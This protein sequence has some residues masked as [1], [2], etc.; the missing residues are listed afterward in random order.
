MN[1][2]VA[3]STFDSLME[4]NL[5]FFDERQQIVQHNDKGLKFQFILTSALARK[6]TFQ[7]NPDKGEEQVDNVI[8]QVRDGSD[9]N[10][11]GY[12]MCDIGKTHF[13]AANKF[14]FARPHLMLLT[15]DG[16]KRQYEPLDEDDWQALNSVLTD[17]GD[18]YVAFFNCGQ[19]GGC[20][21]L[22]KHMQLIPKPKDSFAAFLDTENGVEPDV[23]FQWFYHHFESP[24]LDSKELFGIYNKLLQKA[25]EA[26]KDQSEHTDSLPAGAAIPHNM[27]VT[28]QWMIVLPRRQ[29]AVN[30]KAGANSIGMMGVIAVAT[31]EEIDNWIRIGPVE[32]LKELG[33]PKIL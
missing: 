25:T 18:D 13:L 14:C 10:T 30:K 29:A 8:D 33:V 28:N 12:E 5:V 15:S 3:L 11:T 6:P 7:V 17:L 22:H 1:D 20:S 9:I 23:P 26:G 32:A 21:R 31:Q 16:N 19:N 27:L 24:S 2:S 4:K